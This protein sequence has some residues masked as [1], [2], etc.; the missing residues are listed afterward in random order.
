[1]RKP[2]HDHPVDGEISHANP[3]S[4]KVEEELLQRIICDPYFGTVKG[5]IGEHDGTRKQRFMKAR[6]FPLPDSSRARHYRVST[7]KH[8]Q[9]EVWF[10]PRGDSPKVDTTNFPKDHKMS[11][12]PFNAPLTHGTTVSSLDSSQTLG[13]HGWNHLIVSQFKCIKQRIIRALKD[14]RKE[15]LPLEVVV[16]HGSSAD[17]KEVSNDLVEESKPQRMTR[18][19]SLNESLDKYARLFGESS[20]SES[21]GSKLD[22]SKSLKLTAEDRTGTPKTFR[23]RLSLPDHETLSSILSDMSYDNLYSVLPTKTKPESNKSEE[24]ELN[25]EPLHDFPKI[26][27][28]GKSSEEGNVDLIIEPGPVSVGGGNKDLYADGDIFDENSV[29]FVGRER[30]N[31]QGEEIAITSKSSTNAELSSRASVLHSFLPRDETRPE[32]PCS[33]E[34]ISSL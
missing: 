3:C 30:I 12:V 16:D 8:K 11:L 1:M 17:V 4:T 22:N 14:S 13:N 29:E 33:S 9:G 26:D 32:A 31:F 28:R 7:L 23:R 34:G 27:S 21:K 10:P 24:L 2:K 18:L 6:S 15:S 20:S 19:S 25:V 5:F